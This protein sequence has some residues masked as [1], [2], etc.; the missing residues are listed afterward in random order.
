LRDRMQ[1]SVSNQFDQ[2]MQ[3]YVIIYLPGTETEHGQTNF[4][5][6]G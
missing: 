1:F 2:R 3:N 4:A 6:R 5:K